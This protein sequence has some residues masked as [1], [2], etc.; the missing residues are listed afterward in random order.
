VE[1][2][3]GMG[4]WRKKT[5]AGAPL[6][7]GTGFATNGEDAIDAE[8]GHGCCINYTTGLPLSPHFYIPY[9]KQV[10]N[11]IEV[12]KIFPAKRHRLL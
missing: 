7:S 10:V 6:I 5:A 1:E 9:V 2:E 4:R 3:E 8:E 11:S 12:V